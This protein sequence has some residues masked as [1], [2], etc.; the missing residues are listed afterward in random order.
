MKAETSKPQP[1]E[2]KREQYASRPLGT[3]SLKEGAVWHVDTL[4]GNST[5]ATAK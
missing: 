1:S 2:E 5:T 3:S 4:N